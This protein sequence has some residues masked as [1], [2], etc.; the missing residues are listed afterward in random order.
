MTMFAAMLILAAGASDA[1]YPPCNEELR[2]QGI[3]GEMTN[4]AHRDYD[5]ADRAMNIQ[6]V[7]TAA[8]MK[9]SDAGMQSYDDGQPGFFE[10]LLAAQRAW[11]TYRDAHC[12]SAGYYARGG[13]MEPMLVSLCK[14]NLT[15]ERTEQLRVLAEGY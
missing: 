7:K 12:Q 2:D 8:K 4:C 5:A 1:Y 14:A 15:N 10:T 3:Q 11:L 13:S 9:R 6:W